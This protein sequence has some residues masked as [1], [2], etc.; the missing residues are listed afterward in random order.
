MAVLYPLKTTA[1]AG[2]RRAIA[3]VAG[4]AMGLATTA[5]VA[6]DRG[7]PVER[8]RLS[9]D[10]G[11][12]LDVE[13]AAGLA[14]HAWTVSLWLGA[15]D[16]PLVVY[17]PMTDQ[18]E[19]RL[20]DTRVGGDLA[21]AYAVNRWLELSLAAPLILYQN[22]GPTS[23][24]A[25]SGMLPAISAGG[26]GA[27]RLGAKLRILRQ[28]RHGVDLAFVPAIGLPTNTSSSGYL[29]DTGV[30]ATGELALGRTMG[31]V[32]LGANLGYRARSQSVIANLTVDDEVFAHLGVG[33]HVSDRFEWAVTTS[34][35]AAA[36][37]PFSTFNQNHAEVLTGPIVQLGAG[38]QLM[39][40]GGIGLAQGFGTPDARFLIAAR[41]G[42]HPSP[43]PI[44]KEVVPPPPP[45]DLD[46]DDDGVLDDVDHCV[47]EPGPAEN[48]GCP[49]LDGDGD[50]LIDRLDKCPADA[51]D[52]DS[53][54]DDDG[55]PDLDNDNDGVPDVT[56]ACPLEPGPADNHGCPDP[57]RDGDGI[58]DRLDTCPDE[59]GDA[60]NNGCK[61]K[62]LATI[63]EGKIA[64]VETVYFKTNKAIIEKRSYKLLESVASVLST[65][66]GVRVRIEGHTDSQGDADKNKDLSQRRA[67]AVRKFLVD[68]KID[69]ARFEAVGFGEDRPVAD[70]GTA[71][72]RAANRRVEFVIIDSGGIDV[73]SES[74][75]AKDDTMDPKD[76]PAPTPDK[77][78]PTPDKPAPAPDKPAPADKLP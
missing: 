52:K 43:A 32:Q 30:S 22:S 61:A 21:A 58:V 20:V 44:I 10:A 38:V 19:S 75:G 13:D 46:A 5:A 36:A 54:Q 71:V 77:P 29:G 24:I 74:N 57:D 31:R 17:N 47:H 27:L 42:S 56:D 78:A 45:V 70:N 1:V 50:G 68:H 4:L 2:A 48:H 62:P 64:I 67:E 76:R 72:G 26:I 73:K 23:T 40:A 11:G 12:M 9:S 37:H 69:P 16:D 53:F 49:D 65:H 34:L 63:T 60:A 55:C 18:R 3:I 15:A 25:P 39:A 51:E 35:A 66:V 7:F 41:Y 59:V 28:D 8:F 6:D 14:A 33:V